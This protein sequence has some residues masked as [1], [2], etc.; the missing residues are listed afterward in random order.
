MQVVLLQKLTSRKY[1]VT[2]E[3]GLSFPLYAGEVRTYGIREGGQISREALTEIM[4][5]VLTRRAKIRCLHLLEKMDRTEGQLREKLTRDGYPEEIT[6]RAVAYAA[7]FHY[8]DDDRYAQTYV[9][10]Q[11]TRKSRRQIEAD[12]MRRGLDRELISRA[13]ETCVQEAGES[14]ADPETEAIL[15]LAKKRR[16]DP[17]AADAQETAGFVRYLM[18]KGFSY[19]TAQKAL[20]RC[21]ADGQDW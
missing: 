20:A 7:S 1:K 15:K 3:D 13:Y 8:I 9:R 11:M 2:L 6:E 21:S 5:D 19:R 18:Q 12:L 16:Y 4:D 14:D 10:Q 17:D